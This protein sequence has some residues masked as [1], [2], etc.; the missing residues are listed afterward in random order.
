MLM[1]IKSF[2]C[3]SGEV[4]GALNRGKKLPVLAQ[5]KQLCSEKLCP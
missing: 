5:L 4:V 2:D 3:C 1:L